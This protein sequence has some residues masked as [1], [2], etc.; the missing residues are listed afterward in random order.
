MRFS[1]SRIE[2][3]HL[4]QLEHAQRQID[5]RETKVKHN[6]TRKQW[7]ERQANANYRNEYDRIMGELSHWRGGTTDMFKLR[8]RARDLQRLFSAGN[9]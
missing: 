2:N 8:N 5:A 1:R 7:M 6:A 9:V 4:R 3:M